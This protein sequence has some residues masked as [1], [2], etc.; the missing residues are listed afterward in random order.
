MVEDA[1]AGSNPRGMPAGM[2]GG[3][4]QGGANVEWLLTQESA[5]SLL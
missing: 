2:I 3:A 5:S 1:L 4:R